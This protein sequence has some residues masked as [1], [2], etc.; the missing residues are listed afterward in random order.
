MFQKTKR[1]IGIILVAIFLFAAFYIAYIR[2][3]ETVPS[4]FGYRLVRVESESMEP[5]LGIGEVVISVSVDPETL[6]KGDLI[7]YRGEK[8]YL[9]GQ[10]VTH[11]ISQDPYREDGVLYFTT[12]GIKPESVD[13]PEISEKQIIGKVTHK[14]PYIGTIYDFFTKWYGIVIFVVLVAVL[15][16]DDAIAV[17]NKIKEKHNIDDD[18]D[19]SNV[20]DLK[21][22]EVVFAK[23][24]DEFDGI[25]TDLEEPD[26]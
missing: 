9:N 15:F 5:E 12:R 7:C 4:F 8:S 17:Y 6:V 14:I 24:L 10:L 21:Q 22:S 1:V 20:E 23:R 16:A 3:T 2:V 26:I 19:H 13:D 25:I 11:Q 18:S